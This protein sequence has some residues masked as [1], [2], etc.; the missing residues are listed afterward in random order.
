MSFSAPGSI[1]YLPAAV[2]LLVAIAMGLIFL[3]LSAWLG[4]YVA[5]YNKAKYS[6]YECGVPT[7]GSGWQQFSVRYY[8]VAI[9]FLLFDVEVVFL[10]PWAIS[11]REIAAEGPY[12]L[13][14]MFLFIDVLLAG[15]FYLLRKGA[16][17]W[18]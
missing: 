4:S 14:L 6:V 5:K 2:L 9:I 10:Y 13:V 15:Y 12:A 7:V 11:F 18:D 8:L 3:G 17:N 1:E 16:L